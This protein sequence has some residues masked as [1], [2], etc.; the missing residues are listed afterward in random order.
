MENTNTRQ[1][2]IAK[3]IQRDIAE[4]IQKEYSATLRGILVTVDRKSVV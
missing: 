3:Q 2:K 4:I 1:Q